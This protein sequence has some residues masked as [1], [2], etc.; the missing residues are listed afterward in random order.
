MIATSV[1][2]VCPIAILSR[3]TQ[4]ILPVESPSIKVV[5][6]G[7]GHAKSSADMG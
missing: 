4:R 2:W 1:L 3:Q 6:Q 5:D 7:F